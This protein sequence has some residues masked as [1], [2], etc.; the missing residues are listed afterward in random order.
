MAQ[1]NQP[2]NKD[3]LAALMAT[4]DASRTWFVPGVRNSGGFGAA[5]SLWN[6]SEVSLVDVEASA[7]VEPEQEPVAVQQTQV[8][9]ITRLD[10]DLRDLADGPAAVSLGLRG[11][12][13]FVVDEYRTSASGIASVRP[14][15]QARTR[16]ILPWTG[17]AVAEGSVEIQNPTS[18]Q[19]TAV[20]H[21]LTPEGGDLVPLGDPIVVPPGNRVALSA[22][23]RGATGGAAAL[24]VVLDG[25][26]IVG[27]AFAESG[28]LAS[29]TAFGLE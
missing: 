11:D 1:T 10:L 27:Q 6:P 15:V 5:V 23:E 28:D 2:D 7:Q 9:P 14:A 22:K 25:P 18:T 4:P 8:Q 26:G 13:P 19:I 29:D 16:W 12:E 24:A 3:G 21:Q 17:D 20:L